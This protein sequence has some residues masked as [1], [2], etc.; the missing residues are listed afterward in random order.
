M[1]RHSIVTVCRVRLCR[2]L[3]RII[4][5][6]TRLGIVV[7][8]LIH[9]TGTKYSRKQVLIHT[10]ASLRRSRSGSDPKRVIVRDK[11]FQSRSA[12]LVTFDCLVVVI[13]IVVVESDYTAGG[14]NRGVRMHTGLEEDKTRCKASRSCC[15]CKKD[16]LM[17]FKYSICRGRC[18]DAQC[19]RYHLPLALR[20]AMILRPCRSVIRAKKPNLRFLLIVLG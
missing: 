6:G 1:E 19:D 20:L 15:R 9:R 2:A 12:R 7:E 11:R 16:T 14:A 4:A 10:E 3:G 5:S 13:V 17:P 18:K 8:R